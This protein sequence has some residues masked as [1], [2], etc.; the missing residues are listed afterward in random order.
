M[1]Q[2]ILVYPIIAP[3]PQSKHQQQT[4]TTIVK[5]NAYTFISNLYKQASAFKENSRNESCSFNSK[6]R[7]RQDVKE[8]SL[9]NMVE[10]LQSSFTYLNLTSLDL[11]KLQ[12]IARHIKKKSNSIGLKQRARHLYKKARIEYKKVVQEERVAGLSYQGKNM[13]KCRSCTNTYEIGGSYGGCN[14]GGCFLDLCIDCAPTRTTCDECNQETC[15]LKACKA[16]K[17]R[18]CDR[19]VCPNCSAG[20]IDG[21]NCRCYRWSRLCGDCVVPIGPILFEKNFKH[22]VQA[23]RCKTCVEKKYGVDYFKYD[24]RKQSIRE[25]YK[26]RIQGRR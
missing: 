20:G 22:G 8:T 16:I 23:L 5:E 17:C 7:K 11:D 12:R 6:K 2:A 24:G 13:T 9:E 19:M 1:K 26:L 18:I 3:Q 10:E 21:I 4:P 25:A 15:D 14:V